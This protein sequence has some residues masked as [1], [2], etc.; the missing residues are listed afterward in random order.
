MCGIAGLLRAGGAPVAAATIKMMTDAI[1][2]RG[3]DGEGHWCEGVVAFLSPALDRF[4]S[5][6]DLS[7]QPTR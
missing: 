7:P 5:R 3:P 4:R 6:S 2:H 1:A